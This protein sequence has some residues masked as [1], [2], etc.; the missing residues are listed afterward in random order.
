MSEFDAKK[1]LREEIEGLS[2]V[3]STIIMITRRAEQDLG[4]AE[5]R[6]NALSKVKGFVDTEMSRKRAALRE[7]EEK[8]TK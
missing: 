8:E 5:A 1:A 4:E 2:G 3:S 6:F 7:L